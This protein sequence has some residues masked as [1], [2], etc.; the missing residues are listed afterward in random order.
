MELT[1]PY[2]LYTQKS[3]REASSSRYQQVGDLVIQG[4]FRAQPPS[5]W[6][7]VMTLKVTAHRKWGSVER[8]FSAS[9]GILRRSV[10]RYRSK[11][12]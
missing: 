7:R 5:T 4:V 10:P 2:E 11:N 3:G 1:V 9:Y 6:N 8:G 12:R